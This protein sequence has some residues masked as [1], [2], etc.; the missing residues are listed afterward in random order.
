MIENMPTTDDFAEHGLMFLN[1][2][3][4]NIID[5][6][7][8]LDDLKEYWANTIGE[9]SAASSAIGFSIKPSS[10]TPQMDLFMQFH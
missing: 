4:D 1:L 8:G 5:L 9:D 6:F 3:W 2:A 7:L 10:P